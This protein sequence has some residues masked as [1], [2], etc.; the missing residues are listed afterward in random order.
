M[1]FV[2]K[3]LMSHAMDSG[4]SVSGALNVDMRWL[5]MK[6]NELQNGACV[7]LASQTGASWPGCARISGA[8]T[9]Q[10]LI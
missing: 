1:V 8:E 9:H 2:A 4:T 6:M 3:S 5:K 7:W 10:F